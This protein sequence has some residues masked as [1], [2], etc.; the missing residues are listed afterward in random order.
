[1]QPLPS[2]R[3]RAELGQSTHH[4]LIDAAGSLAAAH[5]QHQRPDRVETQRRPAGGGVARLKLRANGRA[6]HTDTASVQPVSRLRKTDKRL[7]HDPR[8]P[9]IGPPG[10]RVGFMQKGPCPGT[11]GGQDWRRAGKPAHSQGRLRRLGS[12]LVASQPVRSSEPS[13]EGQ[14]VS[15]GQTDCRQSHDPHAHG[16]SSG[17][18]VDFLGRDQQ[19]HFTSAPAQFLGHGQPGKEMTACPTASDGD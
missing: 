9:P 15:A 11:S 2:L 17:L 18:L 8:E 5:H 12:K 19:G 16:R 1:M 7:V 3:P 6:G 14:A 10:D 4:Q 13:K